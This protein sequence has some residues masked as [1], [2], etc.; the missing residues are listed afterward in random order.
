ML[1]AF[2]G[3]ITMT[4]LEYAHPAMIYDMLEGKSHNDKE[5]NQA[6][7]TSLSD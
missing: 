6:A 2:D 4:E 1:E 3:K 7:R 5:R